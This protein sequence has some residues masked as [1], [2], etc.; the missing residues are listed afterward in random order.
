ML[1]IKFIRE[2][3]DLVQKSANDK[4]Y[5]VDIATLLQLTTSTIYKIFHEA[6]CYRQIPPLRTTRPSLQA[7][8]CYH[9][10]R[11]PLP[12]RTIQAK[13]IT[14]SMVLPMIPA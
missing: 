13:W 3:V 6:P 1:D 14:R 7:F 4:G 9:S 12:P 10:R 8:V 2:N 5:A 11:L